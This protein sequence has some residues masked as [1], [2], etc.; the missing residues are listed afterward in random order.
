MPSWFLTVCAVPDL[1]GIPFVGVFPELLQLGIDRIK[2]V[3]LHIKMDVEA[4]KIV[5]E[6][7]KRMRAQNQP[8]ID[9]ARMVFVGG[10]V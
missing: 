6:N 9:N 3:K 2:Q 5:W 10:A 1:A 8:V 4:G 7:Y